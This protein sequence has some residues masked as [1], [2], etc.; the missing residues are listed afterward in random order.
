[1]SK[2]PKTLRVVGVVLALY[3]V[4]VATH[5]GEFWPFSIYPMFSQ[6]GHPWTR[7]LVRTVPN[8]TLD[9]WRA[10]SLRD[11]PGTAFPVQ[12]RGINQN[13]ISNYISKTDRWTAQRLRGLRSLFASA[14]D[15][16]PP[17]LVMRVRG[18]LTQDSVTVRATPFLLFTPDSTRLHADL[19]GTGTRSR[20]ARPP[21]T[22]DR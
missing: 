12:A 6:A 2:Y 10:T 16:S 15:F 17:L 9:S 11:L 8:D 1:M 4:L 13:D 22:A 19:A 3:A 14:H 18:R 20:P 21:P 5:R 7:S